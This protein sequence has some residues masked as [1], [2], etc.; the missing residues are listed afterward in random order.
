VFLSYYI[1]RGLVLVYMC[2][3]TSGRI[4]LDVSISYGLILVYVCPDSSIYIGAHTSIYVWCIY[5][6]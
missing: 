6:W 1:A 2:P 5:V 3:H 4:L